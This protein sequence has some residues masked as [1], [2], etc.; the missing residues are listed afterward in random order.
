MGERRGGER[1]EAEVLGLG[2]RHKIG[3]VSSVLKL[4]DQKEG[5]R[6]KMQRQNNLR[7]YSHVAKLAWLCKLAKILLLLCRHGGEMVWLSAILKW[8]LSVDDQAGHGM[9]MKLAKVVFNSR[10][11]IYLSLHF[12]KSSAPH[13]YSQDYCFL[14]H[15]SVE[16]RKGRK[17]VVTRV[18]II[19]TARWVLQ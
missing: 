14:S 17:E 1:G 12:R 10:A 11:S 6:R 3:F 19:C 15:L 16:G 13:V 18:R 2:V 8:K 9:R 4:R 7:I 5:N